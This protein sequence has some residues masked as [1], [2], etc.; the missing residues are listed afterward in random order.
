MQN[1]ADGGVQTPDAIAVDSAGTV[2]VANQHAQSFT[3]LAGAASPS[4]GAGLSPATGFGLDSGLQEAVAIAPD[5][6]GNVWIADKNGN[7]LFLFF[8]LATPTATPQ[9]SLPSAP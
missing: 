6:S 1:D 9:Q 7:A 3:E 5:R 2:W 8:G 4:P